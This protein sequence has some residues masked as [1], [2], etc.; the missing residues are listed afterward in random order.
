MPSPTF[1]VVTW[2]Y[3]KEDTELVVLFLGD[4]SKAHKAGEFTD[5]F[6]T[7]PNAIFK[8]FSTEFVGRAWDFDDNT[9]ITLVGKQSGNGIVKGG[10]QRRHGIEL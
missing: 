3:N 10:T 5:F 4:T 1:W 8:G 2:W 7:G 9:V 6:L